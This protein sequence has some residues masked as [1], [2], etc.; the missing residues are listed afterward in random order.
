MFMSKDGTAAIM[1]RG[2]RVIVSTMDMF[3]EH[4]DVHGIF[5]H[6]DEEDGRP[7]IFSRND[8]EVSVYGETRKFDLV[9]LDIGNGSSDE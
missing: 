5:S 6:Y 9:R 1:E 8:I 7:H 2:D 3:V 4:P